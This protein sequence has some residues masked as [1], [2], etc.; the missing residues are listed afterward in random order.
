MIVKPSRNERRKIRHYRIRRKVFGTP[1]RPRLSV[2]RSNKHIYAQIIDDTRGVTLA[3]ASTLDPELREALKAIGTGNVQAAAKVGE[4]IAKRAKA[5]GIDKVV[6]DRGGYRYHGRVA[7]LAEAA[8]Q[9]GL[10]F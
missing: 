1:E 5:K 3:S 4:L 2:F 9:G 7:A 6:F 10:D 8:R